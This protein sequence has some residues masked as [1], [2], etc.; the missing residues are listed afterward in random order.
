MTRREAKREACRAAA[1]IIRKFVG[2]GNSGWNEKD[3]RVMERALLELA[4]ELQRR[5]PTMKGSDG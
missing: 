4:D 2:G 5:G 3:D 1:E